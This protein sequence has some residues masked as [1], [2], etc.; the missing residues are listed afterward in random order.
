MP[1]SWRIANGLVYITG[2]GDAESA[3]WRAAVEAVLADPRHRPGMGLIQDHRAT[4]RVPSTAEIQGAAAFLR[5]RSERIGITRWAVVV[6]KDVSYGMGRIA[7]VVFE[8]TSVVSRVFRDM[9]DAEAWV[10]RS[11]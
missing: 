1:F 9:A 10:R 3:H 5:A 4:T 11:R 8:K 2:D 7:G 6:A